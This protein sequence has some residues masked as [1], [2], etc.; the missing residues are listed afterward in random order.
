MI[1][2]KFSAH[3]LR[4]GARDEPVTYGGCPASDVPE[5]RVL[6][7]ESWS[8]TQVAFFM[9]ETILR[10]LASAGR[11]QGRSEKFIACSA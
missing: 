3:Q 10:A 2:S 9:D 1:H 6:A 11:P 5:M 7:H 8:A 4:R